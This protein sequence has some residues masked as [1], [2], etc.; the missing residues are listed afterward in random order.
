[1]A[2]YTDFSTSLKDK[3][4]KDGPI[5][6][7]DFMKYV[8]QSNE[9]GYYSM[10]KN[11]IGKTGD[12]ITA[13]EV[14]QLFGELIGLWCLNIW[15]LSGSPKHFRLI[16]LGPGNGTMMKDMLRATKH[17]PQFHEAMTISL[18]EINKNFILRQKDQITHHSVEWF[19]C[20]ED[21]PS[22]FSIIVAN[23]FFDALPI[24]QYTKKN[25]KWH[26][27]MIDLNDDKQH[28]FINQFEASRNMREF[29]TVKY[30]HL[31]NGSIIETQDEANLILSNISKNIELHGGAALIVDYGYVESQYRSFISTLQAVKNHKYNPIFQEIG[32]ADITSHINFTAFYDIAKLYKA[33]AYGPINQSQF[34]SNM[35][36]DLRKNMLLLKAAPEE[37]RDIIEGYNRIVDSSQMGSL[38]KVLA[39]TSSKFE[40][41]DIG[42]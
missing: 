25:D 8:L 32:H 42:F 29:L 19:S 38:F 4:S 10:S 20:Y 15:Q 5:T 41:W 40:P 7:Y 11:L 26:I 16:E 31:R 13:P 21:I 2:V 24:N 18:V 28:L 3:I 14:S 35:H 22:G 39:I 12:F 36:I 27:N 33:N 23:E 1:M 37:K 30:S 34:L 6:V 17:V 9:C